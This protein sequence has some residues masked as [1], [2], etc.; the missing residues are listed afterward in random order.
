MITL[1]EAATKFGY[2]YAGLLNRLKASGIKG[3]TVKGRGRALFFQ[4]SE[5]SAVCANK[6]RHIK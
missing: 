1:E 2:S 4:L 3:S 6:G 5:L